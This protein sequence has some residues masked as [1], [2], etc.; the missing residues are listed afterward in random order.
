MSIK[1]EVLK[2]KYAKFLE[3]S[4]Y[5]FNKNNILKILSKKDIDDAYKTISE[6]EGY[7][8]TP[9]VSLNKLSEELNNSIKIRNA[10]YRYGDNFL[11]NKIDIDL[12]CGTTNCLLGVSGIGKST[13]LKLIGGLIF[14]TKMEI[15]G[16]TERPAYMAQEDLLLPWLTA[17]DNVILG[18]KLRGKFADKD[19]AQKL[20][21]KVGL[22]SHFNKRPDQLSGGMRQRVALARTLMEN[23]NLVLMDEPFS[24]LDTFNR[25]RLQEL[26]AE[27]LF[28][29]TVLL[30]T[31]DPL[32]ALRLGNR[33]LI[34]R[35]KPCR[36]SELKLF[37]LSK[38]PRDI[39]DSKLLQ[40]HAE[41]LRSLSLDVIE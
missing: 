16:L 40:H 24:S 30:V 18:A 32:E 21:A 4:N 8:S 33:V 25:H 37:G 39:T 12:L 19:K 31:H 41:L 26:T 7:H 20:L 5:K 34:M 9:L 2:W 27:L 10:E 3:N 15:T 29:K 35:G 38:V 17:L 23:K 36:L 14:S 1:S 6:W 11:F 28:K 13:L 22:E